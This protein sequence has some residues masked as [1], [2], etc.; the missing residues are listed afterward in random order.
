MNTKVDCW[1]RVSGERIK[2]I[3]V[4]IVLV[5]LDSDVVV[6]DVEDIEKDFD[7]SDNAWSTSE[8]VP[9]STL[10]EANPVIETTETDR[11]VISPD[12]FNFWDGLILVPTK[13]EIEMTGDSEGN[14]FTVTVATAIRP[15][16]DCTFIVSS[17]IVFNVLLLLLLN[18]KVSFT[19][20]F[21]LM[22]W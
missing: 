17:W 10:Q 18:L 8:I 22:K 12:N 15:S 6:D 9:S 3:I 20:T 19:D 11:V 21:E 2:L 13:L 7:M 14:I 16:R 4:F 1:G 5:E